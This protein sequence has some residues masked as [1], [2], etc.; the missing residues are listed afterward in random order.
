MVTIKFRMLIILCIVLCA[1]I[2]QAQV[3]IG[4]EEKPVTGALLQLKDKANIADG[5]ENAMKGIGMPRVKITNFIPITPTQLATS[6]GDDSGEEWDLDAH[7]GLT[8][9]NVRK[10]DICDTEPRP[11]GL[12]VW[13]GK[14]WLYLGQET[15]EEPTLANRVTKVYDSRDGEVYLAFNF[16][17]SAGTWML[18]NLRY[19]PTDGSITIS[20]GSDGPNDKR[21]FYPQP[22]DGTETNLANIPTWE[23][24]QGLLYSY[25]AITSG[26]QDDVDTDQSNDSKQKAIQ[27]LCP[28][29]WHVPTDYEWNQLERYV[30]KYTRTVSNLY[31]DEL[32]PPT[33]NDAWDT[34]LRSSTGETVP[35]WGHAMKSICP[36][37]GT[38]VPTNGESFHSTQ[39]GFD[40]LLTGYASQG[41]MVKT[42]DGSYGGITYF[43]TGSVNG[44]NN[45]YSRTMGAK[46]N[47]VGREVKPRSELFSLRCKS[48]G[49]Q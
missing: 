46:S 28:N 15:V 1:N 49:A 13:T 22:Q 29:G 38:T 25:A 31:S 26:K 34:G 43:W 7:I 32:D 30:Y 21:Y 39:A 42:S 24:R 20:T 19:L 18:E 12:Y 3:T 5:S 45:A 17:L 8:V 10:P 4:V 35:G 6:I 2:A 36:L 27:G 37:P 48:N 47:A 9:Y 40:A 33:W 14:E 16:G 41:K 44:S 23:K 11:K